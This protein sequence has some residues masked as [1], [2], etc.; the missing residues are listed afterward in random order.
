[1]K[2]EQMVGT[3]LIIEFQYQGSPLARRD[4][5]KDLDRIMHVAIIAEKGELVA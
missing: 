2:T 4:G 5:K 1:M 3:C